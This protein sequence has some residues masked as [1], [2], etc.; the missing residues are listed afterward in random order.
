MPYKTLEFFPVKVM[1]ICYRRITTYSSFIWLQLSRNLD[2]VYKSLQLLITYIYLVK[3]SRCFLCFYTNHE[4][5]FYVTTSI[6]PNLASIFA[7][8]LFFLLFFAKWVLSTDFQRRPFSTQKSSKV[9]SQDVIPTG[10]IHTYL[11]LNWPELATLYLRRGVGATEMFS[12]ESFPH[13]LY[14]AEC[15]VASLYV[16]LATGSDGIENIISLIQANCESL[17][18]TAKRRIATKVDC[19]SICDPVLKAQG[20]ARGSFCLCRAPGGM[21]GSWTGTSVSLHSVIRLWVVLSSRG[22]RDY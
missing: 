13:R 6:P 15:W 20:T 2:D 18:K 7:S 14:L 19:R 21:P 3:S 10:N 9:W 5:S 11:L 22:P 8:W 12:G 4:K 1:E 16:K 17:H